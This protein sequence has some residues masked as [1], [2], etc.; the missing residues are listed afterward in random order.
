MET[1][2]FVAAKLLW[3][4]ARPES[5]IVLLLVLGLWSLRQ[6]RI[7]AAGKIF[8]SALVLVLVIGL[9]PVGQLLLRPLEVRFPAEPDI[10]APAG[11][12][13]LGGGE[14]ARMSVASGLPELNAAGERLVLGLALAQAFPEARLIFTGGS[15]SL[16]DQRISG[17]DGAQ[18]LFARFEIADGRIIL[19]PT[20]R[21]TAE[22]ATRTY[23]LVEDGTHGPWILVTSAFH[24]PRS[25]GCF[26]AAGWRDVIPY[27]VDYR[28]ADF[29]WFSWSFA[30][31][32]DL[33]NI[34][35]KEWIGLVVYSLTGRTPVLLPETC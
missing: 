12:I 6:E 17:A 16:V 28:A 32:L 23:E 5:W 20:A 30:G 14:D 19:E 21:N 18:N 2:F 34:A 4:V 11:I 27:P 8:F 1:L 10:S 31:N 13:I 29:E 22:N 24:M 25:V 35:I 7:A 9:V 33:L 26:C 15:A 3:L